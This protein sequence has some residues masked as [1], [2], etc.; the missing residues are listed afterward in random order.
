MIKRPFSRLQCGEYDRRLYGIVVIL[1]PH[2]V[3]GRA[4]RMDPGS[5]SADSRHVKSE[6]SAQNLFRCRPSRAKIHFTLESTGQSPAMSPRNRCSAR[7]LGLNLVT[8]KQSPL[9]L[10]ARNS[11][12]ISAIL[13]PRS[14]TSMNAAGEGGEGKRRRF[15]DDT[16]A[17]VERMRQLRDGTEKYIQHVHAYRDR[18]DQMRNVLWCKVRCRAPRV[19]LQS[20]ICF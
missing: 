5:R 9:I 6:N 4:R 12:K 16:D 8:P 3:T 11:L 19:A 2:G 18:L 14:V 1:F 10:S 7:N 15:L 20:C 13:S 17:E